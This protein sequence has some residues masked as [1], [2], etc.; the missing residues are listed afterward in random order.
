M[1]HSTINESLSYI[2]PPTTRNLN[3]P[4]W[5]C[6][7]LFRSSSLQIRHYT[8]F[9]FPLNTCALLDKVRTGHPEDQSTQSNRVLYGNV[10]SVSLP[11]LSLSS[12]AEENYTNGIGSTPPIY[13]FFSVPPPPHLI[14]S[15]CEFLY[16][17]R[18]RTTMVSSRKRR[19][20]WWWWRRQE[21]GSW[22]TV[23]L[24][25]NLCSYSVS[26]P[27]TQVTIFFYST[28]QVLRI[29]QSHPISFHRHSN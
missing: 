21:G 20:W 19:R 18:K 29:E 8:G 25:P 1:W 15:I 13:L 24:L 3:Y 5:Y 14:S 11:P 28:V 23:S 9:S 27:L 26:P 10:V 12:L 6:P 16:Y 2:H 7:P 22:L 4:L 17:T